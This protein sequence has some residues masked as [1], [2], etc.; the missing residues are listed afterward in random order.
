MKLSIIVPVYNTE[1]YL[2]K[3]IDSLLNQKLD[4]YEIIVVD[5]GSPDNS[6]EIIKEYE[7]KYP[8]LIKYI[9]K[10]NG[11]LSSARN[12]GLRH[13]QGDYIAFVDSDDYVTSDMYKDMYEE[14]VS[15][16][17]D[18]VACDCAFIYDNHTKIVSSDIPDFINTSEGIKKSMISIFPAAWNKIYKKSLFKHGIYFTEGIWFEDVDFLYRLYPFINS[19]GVVRKPYYQYLQ[20]EGAITSIFDERLFHYIKICANIIDTYKQ[21]NLYES[22]YRELQFVCSRYLYAT[23]MK[24]AVCYKNKEKYNEAYEAARKFMKNNFHKPYLNH[25]FY[26]CGIKGL[27]LLFYNKLLANLVYIFYKKED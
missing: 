1:K 8:D 2:N 19:M 12:E 15:K 13:A 14:A 4:D 11:G 7:G 21:L 16:N 22:Y 18:I 3:C 9:K 27:Y 6:S 10:D 20:R 24:R 26:Q 5:D 23:F 25:Y 17:L